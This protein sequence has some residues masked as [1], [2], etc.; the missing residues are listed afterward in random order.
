M[1]TSSTPM[2]S[3]GHT[4][5]RVLVVTPG[6][7]RGGVETHVLL[8]IRAFSGSD[9]RIQLATLYDG[10]LAAEASRLGVRTHIMKKRFRGD[11]RT[12]FRLGR[13][14]KR[15]GIDI[16]HTHMVGGNLYGRIAGR[17]AGVRGIVS[18]LH[19][20]SPLGVAPHDEDWT[21]ALVLKLDYLM[22]RMSHVLIAT[23]EAVRQ[24][25]VAGGMAA[26]RAVTIR[27]AVDVD[28]MQQGESGRLE[29]RREFGLPPEVPVIGIV[30]RLVPVKRFDLFLRAA[31]RVATSRPDAVFMIVGDGALR[32]DLE[33][34]AAG[35][36]LAGRVIFAGFREDIARV[37]ASI[38]LVVM[39]SDSETTPYAVSEAMA[40]GKPVVATA[41]GGVPEQVE[42]GREGLLC[43]PDDE[44]K[45]A[46]AIIQLL[47][48]QRLREE[49]GRNA[50]R[51]AQ[52]EF[53]IAAMAGR[54]RRLYEEILEGK[55]R[56]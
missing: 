37:V 34:Q 21:H 8:L 32:G 26:H 38:D 14:I 22:G 28:R 30:G 39:C 13:I 49:M 10:W 12:V 35:L 33:A 5:I 43:P 19:Y 55:T 51:K 11:P 16:V 7:I 23:S 3:T 17:L 41:V 47:A 56:A 27:N 50:R 20:G 48:D 52:E 44:E 46:A 15:E 40:M 6:L 54:L 29:V 31:H 24:Q 53:S 2:A 25:L 9:V 36:G 18:T 1:D 45:L 42:S 4:S